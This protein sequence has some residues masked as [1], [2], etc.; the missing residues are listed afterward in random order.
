MGLQYD[1]MSGLYLQ[2]K[3]VDEKQ[4]LKKSINDFVD[5][6]IGEYQ[7]L[8]VPYFLTFH[9]KFNENDPTVFSIDAPKITKDLP[10]FMSNS[11]VWWVDNRRGINECLWMVAPKKKGEKLKVEFNKSG[12]AYLQAKGA[13]P[14]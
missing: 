11:F 10:P 13:M 12:V 3:F 14:S 7:Y 1:Q 6:T 2:K 5:R 8:K 4:S 9:A